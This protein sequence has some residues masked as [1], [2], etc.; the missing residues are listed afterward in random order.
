MAS[1]TSIPCAP[2]KSSCVSGAVD[3]VNH[4]L[5]EV[6][7][8]CSSEQQRREWECR[9]DLWTPTMSSSHIVH[10]FD[11]IEGGVLLGGAVPAYVGLSS[12]GVGVA[13]GGSSVEAVG[14]LMAFR[15]RQRQALRLGC[16][17][18]PCEILN[19]LTWS[20]RSDGLGIT[21]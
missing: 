6:N 5:S 18:V 15:Y 14:L 8:C 9:I 17:E 1:P 3:V 11:D 20:G 13:D 19:G 2:C 21:A 4:Q 12:S 10:L 7:T 16:D